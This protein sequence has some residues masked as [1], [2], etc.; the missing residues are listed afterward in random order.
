MSGSQRRQRTP[1]YNSKALVP[2]AKGKDSYRDALRV[3]RGLGPILPDAAVATLKWCNLS[4]FTNDG[5][6]AWVVGNV[7]NYRVNNA[8]QPV[9]G[10]HQPYGWDQMAALYRYYKVIG[11]KMRFTPMNQQSSNAILLIRQVP[12]DENA[13]METTAIRFAME[14]PGTHVVCSQPGG[15]YPRSYTYD[16]DIPRQLGITPEQFR[17]DVS[18]YS[19]AVTAAPA[20]YA[21]VQV[22]CAGS[23]TTS[24][25]SV[26][27]EIEYTIQYWQRI[28]QASS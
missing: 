9:N 3:P 6:T 10:A 24:F 13:T 7:V 1:N 21:Y 11:C 20:R 16:I 12:V 15:G 25:L 26:A 5:T 23:A 17:A 18:Q 19:A 22:G 8:Y 28:T 27:V 4:T 14:R 2:S